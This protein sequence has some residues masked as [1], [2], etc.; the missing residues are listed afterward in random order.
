MRAAALSVVVVAGLVG[1]VLLYTP[2][3]AQR[4]QKVYGENCAVCHG[5]QGSGGT[6]PDRFG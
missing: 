6:V 5:A 2:Q 1:L 3:Q 4:G